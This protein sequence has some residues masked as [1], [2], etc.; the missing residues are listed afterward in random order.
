MTL[1]GLNTINL[2]TLN[3][4]QQ[5]V[6]FLLIILGSAILVSSVVVHVR[7]KAF[8]RRFRTIIDQYRQRNKEKVDDD[9][10][11][12]SFTRQLSKRS[13]KQQDLHLLPISVDHTIDG[14]V[15]NALD[16]GSTFSRRPISSGVQTPPDVVNGTGVGQGSHEESNPNAGPTREHITFSPVANSPSL[17]IA[18]GIPQRRHTRTSSMNGIGANASTIPPRNSIHDRTAALDKNGTDG[19]SEVQ[20]GYYS[21]AMIGR[22]SQ[23]HNLTLAE[24]QD[25]GGLEY[26]ALEF[27]AILVPAYFILW[28]LLGCL[29]IGAYITNNQANV[30]RTNGLNPWWVGAFNAVSAFN[31]SGM[32]LLDANMIGN[33]AVTSL[34][35]GT[36]VLD[37]LFQAIAVRSGG[38][39]I[40]SITSLRIGLQILYVIMMYISVYPVVITM[41]NSNVYEERSLG[42]YAD[43]PSP[44]NT[45]FEPR[46]TF[47]FFTTIRRRLSNSM[48]IAHGGTVSGRPSGPGVPTETKS[49]FVTQQLRAQ[50]AHD[51]WWIVLAVLFI[52]ITE[53]GSFE[54]DPITYSVFNICFEV[55]SAYGCVGISTG[56]PNEAYSFC[57]GWHVLSKL[58]LCAV[59]LRGRHRGLPVAIDRAVLLPGEH[60]GEAE[61]EDAMIRME[62]TMSRGGTPAAG[63]GGGGGVSRV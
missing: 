16:D 8:K 5:V 40:I 7:K 27:L 19:I 52:T 4:F 58:I 29:G 25:L 32:S 34:P 28:Q 36:R 31:N 47:T 42:I 46:G 6:L 12:R 21:S 13:S 24:R 50:L 33:H 14:A 54:R 17:G 38:F 35:H 62:R 49:H 55:I 3:T 2:S 59:M 39:Y 23:F 60:L 26:H 11:Y 61:E 51:L 45:N 53:T 10:G 63:G 22:N 15:V 57:G 1:A 56:L 9:G 48:S 20:K 30:A 43:D 37:G 41:R 18:S 44:S